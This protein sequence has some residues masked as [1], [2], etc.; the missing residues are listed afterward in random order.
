VNLFTGFLC[1]DINLKSTTE[2]AAIGLPDHSQSD[3]VV[4]TL[5]SLQYIM[6]LVLMD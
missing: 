6:S 4:R 2:S 3:E 5:F 1:S